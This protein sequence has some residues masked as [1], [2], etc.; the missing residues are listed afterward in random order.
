MRALPRNVSDQHFEALPAAVP[1]IIQVDQSAQQ[2]FVMNQGAAYEE[3]NVVQPE[4]ADDVNPDELDLS[5]ELGLE[6]PFYFADVEPAARELAERCSNLRDEL[7]FA[8]KQVWKEDSLGNE[9]KLRP[10]PLKGWE[11]KEPK[12]LTAADMR[13]AL[14]ASQKAC[15]ELNGAMFQLLSSDEKKNECKMKA[16]LSAANL[17]LYRLA[18]DG[19][20]EYMSILALGA[21]WVPAIPL[22]P[23]I[24]FSRD[25]LAKMGV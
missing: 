20:L 19:V 6:R 9:L 22:A 13:Q 1:E 12:D 3:P 23:A 4:E 21:L 18:D 7:H 24:C 15:A 16:S 8:A 2:N 14:C 10:M 17:K 11:Q 25:K 5:N